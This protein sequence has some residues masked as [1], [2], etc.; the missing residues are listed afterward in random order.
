MKICASLT[1]CMR[2]TGVAKTAAIARIAKPASSFDVPRY[3]PSFVHSDKNIAGVIRG[4]G[5]SPTVAG[6][7]SPLF[8][9]SGL[10]NEGSDFTI[11]HAANSHAPFEARILRHVGFGIGHIENV[12]LV[13]EEAAWTAELFPFR[14]AQPIRVKYLDPIFGSATDSFPA[15]RLDPLGTRTPHS[16]PP[17]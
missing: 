5:L 15:H 9:R 14:A 4:H 1:D 16:P 7:A 8:G 10:R 17:R 2:G 13:D 3:G 12:V 11:L 6:G